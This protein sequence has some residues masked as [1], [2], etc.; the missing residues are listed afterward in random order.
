MTRGRGSRGLRQ[1]LRGW[2]AASLLACGPDA[3]LAEETTFVTRDVVV[4]PRPPVPMRVEYEGCVVNRSDVPKGSPPRCVFDPELPLLV[5]IEHPAIHSTRVHVM[6]EGVELLGSYASDLEAPVDGTRK[7]EVRLPEVADA[8]EIEISTARPSR[9]SLPLRSHA[10]QTSIDAGA[11]GRVEQAHASMER[12]L[13]A[14]EV[15]EGLRDYDLAQ[16]LARDAGMLSEQVDLALAAA[17]HLDSR[18]KLAAQILRGIEPEADRFPRGRARVAYAWGIHHWQRG[19]YDDATLALRTASRHAQ[20]VGDA[21]LKTAALPMYAT[22]LV[23]QGYFDA[24]RHWAKLTLADTPALEDVCHRAA[25]LRTIGWVELLLLLHGQSGPDPAPQL[26]EAL[27]LFEGGQLCHDDAAL[28][29]GA[30]L[31]LAVLALEQDA[32]AL[33]LEH[34][35]QI[36][37]QRLSINERVRVAGLEV[38]ILLNLGRGDADVDAALSRL[39]A[40][41]AVADT[42]QARWRQA[43]RQGDV[44]RSQGDP[45]GALQWYLRAEEHLDILTRLSAF[46]VGRS[47]VGV[48]HRD[49]SERVVET[50]REL[51]RPDEA[52]CAARQAHARQMQ[53]ALVPS[54]VHVEGRDE[55]E[56][57]I[58]TYRRAEEQVERIEREAETLAGDELQRAQ[59]SKL[60]HQGQMLDKANTLLR[61]AGRHRQ[62]PR[63]DELY[64]PVPRELLLGLYPQGTDWLIFASDGDETTVHEVRVM[65]PDLVDHPMILSELL[66]RP[67]AAQ[68]ARARRVRVHAAGVA[69]RIDI[70]LLPWEG[71]PLVGHFPVVYGVDLVPVVGASMAE[72]PERRAVLLADPTGELAAADHEV[73]HAAS[74]LT[75]AGWQVQIMSPEQATPSELQK[76]WSGASLLHYAG[77]AAHDDRSDHGLWPPYSGGTPDWPAYLRL[78]RDTRLAAPQILMQG[79]NVPARVILAGC[80]TGVP[81]SSSSG[82][83]LALA[84]LAAGALE[85]IASRDETDDEVAR[86]IGRKIYDGIDD[87]AEWTLGRALQR[88][89]WDRLRTG[90]SVAGYRVW[91]R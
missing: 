30:R 84:F 91:V 31:S 37:R 4:T 38:H 87:G 12:R 48:F 52:L 34:I 20:L 16:Q 24:A 9:W 13:A 17:Y 8:V 89:Q 27:T 64:A 57:H 11:R 50:L 90:A 47:M 85:V 51:G 76:W 56:R 19:R 66:L 39:D 78:A 65:E 61:D 15:T 80:R 41:V 32:S 33:A 81:N 67:F 5:R 73:D 43:V 23:E 2:V 69:Q 36:D 72:P 10:R 74:R 25:T 35:E 26:L 18:P 75:A 63:C 46:G 49:S 88:A 53:A 28:V 60:Q 21:A 83:S 7:L 1:G 6:A 29:G 58:A 40:A 44:R 55:L 45:S 22:A 62:R 86:L 70:H 54:A 71:K 68:L 77:H 82:T 42:P 79:G 3:V 59:A 14:G